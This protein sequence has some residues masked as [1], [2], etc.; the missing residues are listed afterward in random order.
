MNRRGEG[1]MVAEA[2]VEIRGA[3]L[4]T[5]RRG[6]GP[7]LLLCPGGPGCAD[8]LGPVAEMVC[9]R[10]EVIR[11]EPRG[12]GRSEAAPPFDLA[13]DLADIEALRRHLGVQRWI[14]GGH[15]AGANTA[16]AYAL[17]H[18]GRVRGLIYLCG[19]GLQND[20]DWHRAYLDGS[21][22]R[23]ERWPPFP[24]PLNDEVN[25][26]WMRSWRAYLK[27]PELFAEVASL[28]VPTLIVTAE[29]DIRPSWPAEQLA[30]LLP[31]AQLCRIE[32]AEHFI[33]LSHPEPLRDR[34]RRFVDELTAG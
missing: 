24:A 6:Q 4:W 16:L 25:R 12:C 18:P 15:S 10:T 7:A 2:M 11:F 5:A 23:G 22:Q 21:Q 17:A 28:T 27:R 14:L 26:A 9:D 33:W 3:R 32:G 1:S 20:R 29:R 8:Y 31:Q 30:R 34:L 13:G 19:T